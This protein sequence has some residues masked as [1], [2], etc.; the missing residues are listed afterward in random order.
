MT[1]RSGGRPRDPRATPGHQYEP[2]AYATDYVPEGYEP[3]RRGAS[4]GPNGNGGRRRGGGGFFG[5]VKFLAFALVLA[6]IV[7]VVALTALRPV[8]NSAVLSWAA[9]NPAAL[10]LPF[11]ADLVKEDLGPA[12][13]QPASTDA[14]QV[15]FVV[16]PG[17]TASTIAARLQQQGLVTDARAFV[18]IASDRNLTGALQKGT[19]ILRKSMTPDQMVT[20]LLAPQE[21]PAV[22]IPLRTGLRLEQITALLETLPLTMHAQDFYD[23]VKNPPPALLND[24]PWLKR[25][26][27]DAPKGAS[28][29][30]FLWPS[31]YRVLPDTT[32]EEL[33]RLMLDRFAL[34]VGDARMTVPAARGMTFYQVLTM[35]SIVEQEAKLDQERALIAGVFANRL[36]PKKFPTRLLQSD[37]TVFYAHDTWKLSSMKIEDWKTYVFW[38]PI[39]GGLTKDALPPD[40]ALYNTYT[41]PGLPPGPIC[42]P[43]LPSLDAALEPD[44]KAG[45]LY[46]LAK[47]DGTDTTAFAKTLAEHQ[48]N[49]K[50]Y[51]KP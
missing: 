1:L 32:P 38:A 22:S 21:V 30:G 4:R 47:G 46:F 40:V 3:S 15:E 50:K 16:E 42:T 45:Y 36:D 25:V 24:Y 11:I 44:T 14:T 34:N 35:A 23:L 13:V 12:L 26:L 6:G 9:D 17:D 31:T 51:A 10:R 7:L 19:F 20:A 2:D 33:V 29:E 49:I 8:V 5:V 41:T 39:P 28:L 18:F 37:V 27:A 48:K 43:T